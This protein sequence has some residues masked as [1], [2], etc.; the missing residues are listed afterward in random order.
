MQKRTVKVPTSP[1]PY[2]P[3]KEGLGLQVL[4]LFWK[5]QKGTRM[6]LG[7]EGRSGRGRVGVWGQVK[8][9]N[10]ECYAEESHALNT[11]VLPI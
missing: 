2:L 4:A 9:M 3:I 6:D 8:Q 1:K 7:R 5:S 10:E 11:L